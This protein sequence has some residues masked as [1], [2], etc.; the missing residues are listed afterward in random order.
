ML[1]YQKNEGLWWSGAKKTCAANLDRSHSARRR[2][3]NTSQARAALINSYQATEH[4]EAINMP[5]V[6]SSETAATI[7]QSNIS[8]SKGS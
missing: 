4:L 2:S 8:A 5:H 1:S 7:S 6:A 3:K